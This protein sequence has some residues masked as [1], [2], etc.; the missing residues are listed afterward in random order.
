MVSHDS[1][2]GSLIGLMSNK[3][4]KFGGINL[5]Q[6]IPAFMPPE[7]L[8]NHYKEVIDGPFHQY[9]PGKGHAGLL[10][11]L[12]GYLKTEEFYNDD[13]LLMVNGATEALSLLYIYISRIIN[14]SFTILAFDPIYESYREL[15]KIFNTPFSTASIPTSSENWDEFKI[16]VKEKNV[17]LVF[18][19]SPGNPWGYI[20][21][22]EQLNQLTEIALELDFFVIIDGVYKEQY[23]DVEPYQLVNPSNPNLFYV[24]SFSKMLSVT[25]W[26]IGYISGNPMHMKAISQMLTT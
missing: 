11:W 14:G 4:K 17:K 5:A 1:V 19:A 20:W 25:G 16:L 24:N 6:G 12:N 2:E 18:L 13:H 9:A 23:F 21:S 8:I 15:P 7:E 10:K 26:R 3:V 22:K